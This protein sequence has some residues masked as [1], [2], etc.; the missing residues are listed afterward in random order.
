MKYAP[1]QC[2]NVGIVGRES[3]LFSDLPDLEKRF[4]IHRM[5]ILKF[6]VE[7]LPFFSGTSTRHS[8]TD[9]LP[10]PHAALAILGVTRI[11]AIGRPAPEAGYS[12]GT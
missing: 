1:G 10:V 9:Q 5:E 6:F 2:L 3:L 12:S 4:A 11:V 7:I 8:R